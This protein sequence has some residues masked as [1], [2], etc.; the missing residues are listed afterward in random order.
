MDLMVFL[1]VLGIYS[2]KLNILALGG[3]GGG[4]VTKSIRNG[5]GLRAVA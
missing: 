4:C 5:N 3:S 1:Y 2:V